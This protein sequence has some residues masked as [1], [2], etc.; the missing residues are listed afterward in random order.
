MDVIREDEVT[1]GRHVEQA[2][3]VAEGVRSPCPGLAVVLTSLDRQWTSIQRS[4]PTFT[5]L[6]CPNAIAAT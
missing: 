2:E 3:V 6:A 1:L 5:R 4:V